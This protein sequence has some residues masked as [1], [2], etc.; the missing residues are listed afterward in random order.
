MAHS[1]IGTA[2]L[3]YALNITGTAQDNDVTRACNAANEMVEEYKRLTTGRRVQFFPTYETRYYTPRGDYAELNIDDVVTITAVAVDRVGDFS[4][5]E[6]WTAGTHYVK[7]PVNNPLE[8][9]PYRRLVRV[10]RMSTHFPCS[11][12]SVSVTGTFGWA[13]TPNLVTQAAQ[14]LAQ[15]YYSRRNAVFGVASVGVDSAAFRLPRE[16]PDVARMLDA[17]DSNPPRLFA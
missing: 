11:P 12:Q 13:T 1:Y 16:D 9:K 14:I 6:A 7:E 10:P 15:R 2:E 4:Y 8:G 5:S 17:V 3:K